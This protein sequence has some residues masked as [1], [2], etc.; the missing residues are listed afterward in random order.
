MKSWWLSTA[1]LV[2]VIQG[3]WCHHMNLNVLW[4]PEGSAV[5]RIRLVA[6]MTMSSLTH[7]PENIGLYFSA[8]KKGG[9]ELELGF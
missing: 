2:R 9:T 8:G 4:K 5:R 3:Y 6:Q 7:S 1:L